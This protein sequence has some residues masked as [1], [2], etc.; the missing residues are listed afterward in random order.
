MGNI[1]ENGYNYESR[2]NTVDVGILNSNLKV[3]V[4]SGHNSAN[5]ILF[6][7]AFVFVGVVF[8]YPTL[9]VIAEM[10]YRNL[11]IIFSMLNLVSTQN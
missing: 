6:S 8:K 3:S 10:I 11:Y 7:N 2:G 4:M 5:F 9:S 1:N